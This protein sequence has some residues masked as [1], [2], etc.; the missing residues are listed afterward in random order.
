MIGELCD[1]FVSTMHSSEAYGSRGARSRITNAIESYKDDS[2]KVARRKNVI[3]ST[4]HIR[5]NILD[6]RCS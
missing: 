1:S 5:M 4:P 6:F 3:D 2:A